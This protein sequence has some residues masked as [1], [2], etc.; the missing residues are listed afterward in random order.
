MGKNRLETIFQSTGTSEQFF[1]EYCKYLSELL[2]NLDYKA[3]EK[4]TQLI[5]KKSK[6]GQTIFLIGNGGSAATASHFAI[7]LTECSQPE[8]GLYFRAISLADNV[9]L[10]TALGNDKGYEEVFSGQ[11][12]SLFRRGDTLIAISA[13]GN[14]PNVVAASRLAKELGGVTV[15]VVGFD[16]GALAQIC[17]YVVHV[18]TSKAE[19]GPVEDIHLILDHMITSYLRMKLGKT[20]R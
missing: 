14:S 1:K 18:A 17:D 6:D 3:I 4:V 9:P 19:Y 20:W 7:D 13:S 2:G 12:R 11:V 10:L 16:G 5:L 15:G 8:S